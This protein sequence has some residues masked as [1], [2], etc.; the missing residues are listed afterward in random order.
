[1]STARVSLPSIRFLQV[2]G[3]E[4]ASAHKTLVPGSQSLPPDV[5]I[6][7]YIVRTSHSKAAWPKVF[8][9]AA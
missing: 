3:E 9:R 1:M 4:D 8:L 2:S 5:S 7:R 6:H